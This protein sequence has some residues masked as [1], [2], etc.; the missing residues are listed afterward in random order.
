MPPGSEIFTV[1][2]PL[3]TTLLATNGGVVVLVGTIWSAVRQRRA[4]VLL[5]ALGVAIAGTS[6]TFV[7]AG[8]DALVPV[9]L[10]GGVAVMYAGRVVERGPHP[11]P[12]RTMPSPQQPPEHYI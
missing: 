9:A 3:T 6:S 12:H 11:G 1:Q 4:A 5:I 2:L 8:L 7:R 10:T